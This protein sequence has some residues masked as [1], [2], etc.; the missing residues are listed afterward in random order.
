MRFILSIWLVAALDL[1][2]AGPTLQ[3][4]ELGP[5]VNVFSSEGS[6]PLNIDSIDI[7]LNPDLGASSDI[8]TDPNDF[9]LN[10]NDL[11]AGSTILD[12]NEYLTESENNP[13]EF[14]SLE[15]PS[16]PPTLQASC[17]TENA[18]AGDILR[19]RDDGGASCS[20]K[21]EPTIQLPLEFFTD[22]EAA[23]RRL[24]LKEPETE[25]GPSF[26]SL[27]PA[28]SGD[29]NKC[30]PEFPIRCCTNALGEYSA[31]VLGPLYFIIPAQCI[32]GT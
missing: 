7:A 30:I 11:E 28:S 31:S 29:S 6:D 3:D 23:Y 1:I 18:P 5:D 20:N 32:P 16:D 26:P 2:L 25:K 10:P 21:E 27:P 19:A 8:S 22:I 9:A 24:F 17:G 13:N 14:D 12:W 4:D 15:I